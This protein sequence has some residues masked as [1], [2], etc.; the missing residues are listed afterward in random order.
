MDYKELE[1]KLNALVGV[2]IRLEDAFMENGGEVTEEIEQMMMTETDLKAL[3]SSEGVDML[4][5][6]LK[7][8]EDRKKALKAEKDYVARQIEANDASIAFV[9]EKIMQVMAALG[10]EKVKGNLGYSFTAT[11]STTTSVDKDVL[12]GTYLEKVKEALTGILPED[13]SVSLSA[14]VS[15]VAE[16]AELPAYYSRTSEPSVR[17][18]KPRASKEA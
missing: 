14:S 10:E 1:E 6:W 4:G 5:R 17:F 9:K 3:L 12:N 11:T 13:V 15:K 18:V 2:T 8:K 7:S 16:G